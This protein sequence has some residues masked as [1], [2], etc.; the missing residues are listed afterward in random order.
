VVWANKHGEESGLEQKATFLMEGDS[1]GVG[2]SA[3][4]VSL[5]SCVGSES[6]L[7]GKVG[8]SHYHFH[9]RWHCHSAVTL[10]L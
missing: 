6:V 10:D 7:L 5:S 8:E 4:G 2:R 9:Y 3:R 1:R